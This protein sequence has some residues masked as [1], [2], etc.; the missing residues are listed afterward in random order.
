MCDKQIF[1]CVASSVMRICRR[2]IKAKAGN[3]LWKTILSAPPANFFVAGI[4]EIWMT[5]AVDWNFYTFSH[6][7][8]SE[9][10]RNFLRNPTKYV[11]KNHLSTSSL[12]VAGFVNPL[13]SCLSYLG[14]K[15][16]RRSFRPVRQP[17]IHRFS[18]KKHGAENTGQNRFRK[19]GKPLFRRQAPTTSFFIAS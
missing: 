18:T 16:M 3:D 9:K 8:C 6:R 15:A 4:Q 5:T 10:Q 11:P 13:F 7:K 17:F 19:T 1:F 2:K 12:F 14:K